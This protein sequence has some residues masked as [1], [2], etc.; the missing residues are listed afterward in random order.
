VE[1]AT[2]EVQ[3]T[4]IAENL[5][6][7]RTCEAT[8]Q[9]YASKINQA[10]IWFRANHH[11][12]LTEDG[13]SF[14]LPIPSGPLLAFFGVLG[15]AAYDR[16]H[17]SGSDKITPDMVEPMSPSSLQGYRSA[18]IDLYTNR[19]LIMDA[20]V[21]KALTNVLD[22]YDKLCRQLRLKA[23]MKIKEGKSPIEM[24]GYRMLAEK[25]MKAKVDKN[26]TPGEKRV[27]TGWSATLFAWTFFVLMWN[28]MS[29]SDSVDGLML[30]HMEWQGDCLIIEEQGQKGDQKGTDS[31]GKHIYA[32]PLDPAVCPILSL[33][34]L[35]FCSGF[36]PP[37]GRQQLFI[38]TNN[39]DRFGY[40]LMETVRNCTEAELD[41]LGCRPDEVG[42]HSERKGSS[43][44]CL[45][46]VSGPTPVAVFLR[47]GQS[48]GQL[49][50]RYIFAGEGADQLC[51]RMVCGL[52]FSDER[53]GI[54]PP[55][56]AMATLELL[57]G[58]VWNTIVPGYDN[59][60]ACFRT[61]FPFLLVSLIHHEDFL[62]ANLRPDHPIWTERV[63]TANPC[64]DSLRGKTLLGFG[65]C[66]ITGMKSSGVPPH[67]AIVAKL[68]AMEEKVEKM[69]Q[70]VTTAITALG[71]NLP[72]AVA[73][74]VHEMLR[75][76]FVINGQIQPTLSD[77]DNRFSAQMQMI[78]ALI[79]SELERTSV[80][81]AP[82][83]PPP[84]RN[85][86]QQQSWWRQFDWGDGQIMHFVPLGWSFPRGITVK[87]LWDLW[88]FGDQ[89]TGIR[90]YR[91]INKK[92]DVCAR[93][94]MMYS[95]AH[96]V[97]K[98]INNLIPVPASNVPVN[99]SKLSLQEA[100]SVFEDAYQS[101]L[102]IIYD[103]AVNTVRK[104]E[105]NYSTA[106]ELLCV[107]DTEGVYVKK[108]VRNNNNRL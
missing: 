88:Y 94:E 78:R 35:I 41:R 40:I 32:N 84:E 34:I 86:E 66:L 105:L 2:P 69:Q 104:H 58:E 68:K 76:S 80:K 87:K 98:V 99:I 37:N 106:H 43:S 61:I 89:S 54:L 70:I 52:P 9:S 67:L 85:H 83:Q 79:V 17:L 92:F 102:H 59:Y 6:S 12:F 72:E 73:V 97:L 108:R 1:V 62:R 65:A 27:A 31:Y 90:P 13:R 82:G 38:G 26:N 15:K 81:A 107:N 36:R 21:S 7:K 3:G 96:C 77:L 14:Q 39:K 56:F 5:Q 63:F 55:H 91:L 95:R 49:K 44:Y 64:I 53:F 16:Q 20:N 24:S 19:N 8:K 45:G 11:D 33:A 75:A 18:I 28:L 50:D 101:F 46:Q 93:D 57:T 10:L 103:G 47:M 25:L 100:D 42:T 29:R 4:I 71:E 48:L 60:P 51:G 74:K 22:G 30:Q 23:L